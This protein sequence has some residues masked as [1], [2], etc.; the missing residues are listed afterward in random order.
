LNAL[1][2]ELGAGLQAER[3]D[4]PWFRLRIQTPKGSLAFVG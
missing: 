2:G 1:L 4:Q 3:T